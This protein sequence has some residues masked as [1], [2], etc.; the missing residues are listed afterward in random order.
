MAIFG[1]FLE[2]CTLTVQCTLYLI[3]WGILQKLELR[4]ITLWPRKG[5]KG[6]GGGGGKTMD[7]INTIEEFPLKA[8]KKRLDS[9]P[10]FSLARLSPE[11]LRKHCWKTTKYFFR[12]TLKATLFCNLLLL[13]LL[14]K[15]LKE[16]K[17]LRNKKIVTPISQTDFFGP[18]NFAKRPN[19]RKIKNLLEALPPPS[20]PPPSCKHFGWWPERQ[21]LP[22]C[23]SPFPFP[24]P[25]FPFPPPPTPGME[26]WNSLWFNSGFVCPLYTF[27]R[28]FLLIIQYIYE[29]YR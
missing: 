27:S 10:P 23:Y 16:N 25:P 26:I 21:K 22:S 15:L 17:R 3:F 24:S 12:E 1:L 19:F 8:N 18:F 7:A 13:L 9:S 29:G 4:N 2:Q 28:N 20:P 6:R 11:F 14:Y 5:G